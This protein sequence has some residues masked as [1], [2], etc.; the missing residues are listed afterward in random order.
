MN[1]TTL[2]FNKKQASRTENSQSFREA[3]HILANISPLVHFPLDTK[4]LL[5]TSIRKYNSCYKVIK[6]RG[7]QEDQ[8]ESTRGQQELGR[9]EIFWS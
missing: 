3:N 7:M 1:F 9:G 5:C 2:G 4:A 8:N 6:I